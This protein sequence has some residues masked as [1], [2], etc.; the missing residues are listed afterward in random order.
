MNRRRLV[1]INKDWEFET[2]SNFLNSRNE[3]PNELKVISGEI[4]IILKIEFNTGMIYLREDGKS[5]TQ[6]IKIL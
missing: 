6:L 3:Q 4:P 2:I 5:N 1:K